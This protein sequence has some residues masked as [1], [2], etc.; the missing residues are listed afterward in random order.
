[1][2]KFKKG[3]YSQF[4]SYTKETILDFFGKI[5]TISEYVESYLYPGYFYDKYSEILNI[6]VEELRQ[7]GQ[8]CDKPDMQKEEFQKELVLLELFK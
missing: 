4:S 7:V 2:E 8:L 1:M 3:L 6:P 5:G